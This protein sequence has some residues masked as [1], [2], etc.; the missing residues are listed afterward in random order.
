MFLHAYSGLK[1][2]GITA[3][4]FKCQGRI[5]SCLKAHKTTEIYCN[6]FYS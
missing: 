6:K 1:Q 3:N 2:K 5:Q 4:I